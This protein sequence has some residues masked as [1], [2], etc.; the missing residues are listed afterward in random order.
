MLERLLGLAVHEG[1]LVSVGEGS[2]DE[3]D[4]L[5]R[6]LG[7]A[8][9]EGGRGRVGEGRGDEERAVGIGIGNPNSYK[10]MIIGSEEL[11][12]GRHV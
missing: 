12:N 11:L 8:V 4:V 9:H 7:L 2:G 1:G 5:E 3:A 10:A 6:L